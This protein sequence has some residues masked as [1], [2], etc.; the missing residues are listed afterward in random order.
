MM[1][2]NRIINVN[3]ELTHVQKDEQGRIE[4]LIFKDTF[5]TEL[6]LPYDPRHDYNS[7]ITIDIKEVYYNVYKGK[8]FG[9]ISTEKVISN[10]TGKEIKPKEEIPQE[11]LITVLFKKTNSMKFQSK[12][13]GED[14]ELHRYID[15]VGNNFYIQQEELYEIFLTD[16]LMEYA[17]ISFTYAD[18]QKDYER[19]QKKFP[20]TT[21][22]NISTKSA[23]KGKMLDEKEYDYTILN[24]I[25]R[26]QKSRDERYNGEN[27][28]EIYSQ[29]LSQ[30]E[31]ER[32]LEDEYGYGFIG[33]PVEQTLE[34]AP[35]EVKEET[36]EDKRAGWKRGAAKR[37]QARKE[38]VQALEQSIQRIA[39]LEAQM[40]AM[41]EIINNLS[42]ENRDQKTEVQRL[43]QELNSTREDYIK[44]RRIFDG[45]DDK[46]TAVI[47]PVS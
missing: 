36:I 21:A 35:D 6:T 12:K 16:E 4:A 5:G 41:Q 9:R 13:N 22:A 23:R 37:E 42:T 29:V 27:F 45:E 20:N 38:V 19:T 30:R 1:N 44:L 31:K 17:T 43:K 47:Y 8:S 33:K 18:L 46:F 11:F 39:T 15:A 2:T 10:A 34:T 40:I 7:G 3:F 28:Y 14:V 26:G 32:L 24:E 25:Y